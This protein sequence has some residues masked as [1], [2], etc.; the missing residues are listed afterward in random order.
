[1]HREVVRL[2]NRDFSIFQLTYL[3]RFVYRYL[4]RLKYIL[5]TFHPFLLL[6]QKYRQPQIV[7]LLYIKPLICDSSDRERIM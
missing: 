7:L 4:I 3:I 5:R 2:V 1:M 6:N